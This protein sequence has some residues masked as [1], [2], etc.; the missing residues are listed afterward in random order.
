MSYPAT[1]DGL[2]F[3]NRTAHVNTPSTFY[4]R[5]EQVQTSEAMSDNDIQWED[6]MDRAAKA[7]QWVVLDIEEPHAKFTELYGRNPTAQE[8]SLW[9]TKKSEDL[10]AYD[11]R[12]LVIPFWNNQNDVEAAHRDLTGWTDGLGNTSRRNFVL[13]CDAASYGCYKAKSI[14]APFSIAQWQSA[15]VNQMITDMD[16]WLTTRVYVFLNT[17]YFGN[18]S[19]AD[20]DT[21]VTESDLNNMFDILE[22]LPIAGYIWWSSSTP[23]SAGVGAFSETDPWVVVSEE[24][25]A[26]R[27]PAA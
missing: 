20:D 21:L 7:S 26:V 5:G 9:R 15:R 24:R 13:S 17:H 4:A 19:K 12:P 23:G 16:T 27:V 1:H 25:G 14:A 8:L 11:P 18:P 2:V 6:D 22:A 3:F 10:R